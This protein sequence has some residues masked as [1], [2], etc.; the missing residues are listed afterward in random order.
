MKYIPHAISR[1]V[2][3]QVLV[4]RKNSPTILLGAGVVSMVGSTVL[5]CRAT[6]QLEEVFDEIEKNKKKA[7]EA[8][9]YVDSGQASE[10]TTY[11]E[12]EMEEDLR[13]IKA[14]GLVKIAKLYAPSV[15]LGGV[16]LV[17][18]TKSHQILKDRNAA[19]TAA[20]VA[21]D[22][23]FRMYRQRV[24]ER[25]G[26]EA[27]REFRYG[28]EEVTVIDE[29]TGKAVDTVIVE[30][31]EPSGYAR[32]FD[33]ENPNFHAAPF[34]NHNWKW[35][36]DQQNWANDMLH[37]RGHLF[38]NEVYAMIG[39]SHTS[40]GAIVGWVWDPN[41][42]K[43]TGD[44]WVDFGCWDE[45]G[46]R[47]DFFRGMNGREGAILLDFNVDGPIWDLIDKRKAREDL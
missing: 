28:A 46:H 42:E 4:A 1:K 19:L 31:G 45:N 36:R 7:A 40:A 10:G 22:H 14:K 3:E 35:L 43:H 5:A 20:Y 39:L 8:K 6:L 16:G 25:Y 34:D 29:E 13:I 32:W 37:A 26:E 17:C 41:N 44:N 2:A 21:V 9:A 33:E 30:P 24:V 38:L 47:N 27:D 23:A 15:I 18:L 11:S 12:E